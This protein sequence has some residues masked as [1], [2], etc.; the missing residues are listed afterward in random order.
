MV[1]AFRIYVRPLILDPLVA[2]CEGVES[3]C[4]WDYLGQREGPVRVILSERPIHLLDPKFESWHDLLL[5]AADRVAGEFT[6]NGSSI[7]DHP[8]GERNTVRIRHPLGSSLPPQ[9]AAFIDMP[10]VPLP[11]D[12]NMP[13]V[14]GPSFG[15]SERFAV[16]PGREPEGYFHM[17]CGQSAHPLSPYYRK[18]HEDW[19]E[20]TPS[21]F[22]PG[23]PRWRLEFRPASAD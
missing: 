19:V 2:V 14:Q 3:P 4:G 11:G 6:A 20:G 9:I 5:A 12:D 21:P 22:L 7:A 16:S 8:W 17:P 1:R 10:A 13:R 18:G 15:A 23:L